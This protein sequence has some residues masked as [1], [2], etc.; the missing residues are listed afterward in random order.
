MRIVILFA[1]VALMLFTTLPHGA[2]A[3][4]APPGHFIETPSHPYMTVPMGKYRSRLGWLIASR[5]A[6]ENA[7][8][9]T[10]FDVYAIAA[11]GLYHT[12][13][14][15]ELSYYRSL[16]GADHYR[17]VDALVR[18]FAQLQIVT[19]VESRMSTAV[20]TLPTSIFA[21]AMASVLGAGVL[22][23]LDPAPELV[24]A[25]DS[26][27]VAQGTRESVRVGRKLADWQL[28]Y[29]DLLGKTMF[30]EA[31]DKFARGVPAAE[32]EQLVT[33]SVIST[34]INMAVVRYVPD[35]GRM[36][37]M[38]RSQMVLEA[39]AYK[40]AC[41]LD[42]NTHRSPAAI[43]AVLGPSD[44]YRTGLAFLLAQ[45]LAPQ[46]T[47]LLNIGAGRTID[48]LL[49]MELDK[50]RQIKASTDANARA[51]YGSYLRS[52][53]VDLETL[54]AA[55]IRALESGAV[56][57]FV[58]GTVTNIIFGAFGA[59]GGVAMQMVAIFANAG[60]GAFDKYMSVSD[61]IRI[62]MQV[63]AL[64]EVILDQMLGLAGICGCSAGVAI[65]PERIIKGA[66]KARQ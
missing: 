48:Q 25:L 58:E 56:M 7:G 21:D 34:A 27:L 46:Q 26:P 51:Q 18:D 4:L 16:S 33:E 53:L 24:K 20:K 35:P 13:M 64:R 43:V 19:L 40:C 54:E 61:E 2:R 1:A 31:V 60:Y 47:T 41:A 49:N 11:P 39:A 12:A 3:E 59:G 50:L 22:S 8:P 62:R 10:V 44:T 66:P 15:A 42:Q 52:F 17:Y 32:I 63:A 36:I 57:S 55:Q 6:Y 9:Y 45:R 23:V 37:D 14:N 65:V 30:E 28:R 5:I 38:L 29:A